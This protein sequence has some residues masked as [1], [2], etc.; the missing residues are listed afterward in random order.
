MTPDDEETTALYKCLDEI[1]FDDVVESLDDHDILPQLCDEDGIDHELD[2]VVETCLAPHPKK[3]KPNHPSEECFK[4][5]D[6][7]LDKLQGH[8]NDGVDEL[9][10]FL[11]DRFRDWR[12]STSFSGIDAPHVASA[13]LADKLQARIPYRRINHGLTPIWA[14]E[15]DAA[16]Q[17]ELLAMPGAEDMCLFGDMNEFWDRRITTTMKNLMHDATKTLKV[18]QPVMA[19]ALKTGNSATVRKAH[20]LRHNRVCFAPT[21]DLH[22]AGTPCPAF[23]TIGKGLKTAD[24]TIVPTCAWICMRLNIEEKVWIQENVPGFPLQL[25]EQLLGSLYW[26]SS[27]LIQNTD[28]GWP[29]SR[30]RQWIVGRHKIK[31]LPDVSAPLHW[32]TKLFYRQL[33]KVYWRDFLI[34]TENDIKDELAYATSRTGMAAAC[35]QALR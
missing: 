14:I 7:A 22:I 13:L 34:A 10:D 26:I 18:L 15:R 19:N 28:L 30:C 4:W 29:V 20:C 2:R 6:D 35:F 11:G 27:V 24:P 23:S 5:D 9:R 32:F 33:G 17:A 16:C 8:C 1:R 31:T 12:L 25:L 3:M 21:A